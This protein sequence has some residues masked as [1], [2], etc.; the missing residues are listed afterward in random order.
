MTALAP[1]PFI[2]ARPYTGKTFTAFKVTN[3]GFR[4]AKW[5]TSPIPLDAH[6]TVEEA[7]TAALTGQNQPGHKDHLLIRETD[8]ETGKTTVHLFAIRKSAPK[9]VRDGFA[10]RRVEDL[11]ADLVVVMDGEVL[12]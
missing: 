12:L 3:I 7:K 9:F 11:Y 10:T 1:T 6:A 5:L 4:A 2:A 8:D